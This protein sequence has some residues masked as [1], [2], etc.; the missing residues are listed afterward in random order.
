MSK[1]GSPGGISQHFRREAKIM[2][3]VFVVLMVLALAAGVF[4]PRLLRYIEVDRCLD[5]G[6]SYEYDT[7]AC[8]VERSEK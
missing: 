3:G 4:G 7:A 1:P 5:A 2:A 6:G 8:K